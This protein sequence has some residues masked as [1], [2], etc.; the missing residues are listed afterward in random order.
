MGSRCLGGTGPALRVS[1]PFPFA[2]PSLF[3]SAPSSQLQPQFHLGAG[4][5]R[6]GVCFGGEGGH[7]DRASF[8]GVLQSSFC[9][10]QG[11]RWVASGD[12][13]L[14]PQ[15]LGGRLPFPYG[16]CSDRAPVSSG[17]GL[18]GIPGSPGCLPPGSGSSIVSTVPE[19]LRWGLGLPV[20]R[21]LF[22]SLD[23]SPSVHP[24]HGSCVLDHASSRVPH[25]PVPQRLVSPGFDL[26]G[27][28]DIV[29]AR[30]FLLWLYHR[31]DLQDAYLQ[32]PVHPSSRRYL[33]FCVGDSV[34]QFR[35]LCF[36][37]S[38]APQAFTR[39]MAPVSSIMHCHGFR[40]L[41]YLND[42]LVLGST[43]QDIVRARDFLLWLC[44]RLRIM[45]NL[46][47]SSLDPSQTQDYLGMTITT[48]PLRVFLTL[49]QVQKL[50]LLLQEFRSDRLHPVSVWRRL[51]G[52][53]SSMSAIVP[54]AHLRMRSL[55]LRLNASGPLV[56]DEDLVSWDD[57]C[58]RDLR[59][60]SRR[61][62]SLGRPS[63]WRGPPR[64]LPLLRRLGHRLGRGSRRPP[65]LRLVV[66]PVFYLFNQPSRAF[67]SSL[68]GS[69]LSPFAP[70]S[71]CSS[72]F[73]QLHRFSLPQETRGHS[74]VHLECSRSGASLALRGSF[75]S[76]PSPVH[77]RPSE[78]SGGFTQPSFSS[79]GVRVDVVSEGG[80]RSSSPLAYQ[81][82]P[83]RDVP[84]S[85]ASGVL[86]ANVRSAVSWHG[87]HASVVGRPSGL[88]L[89]TFQP[90]SAC[91][92]EGSAFSGWS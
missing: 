59:W 92:G 16:D 70:G 71:S 40:I 69:G 74:F 50:S 53:M 48:S 67:G 7:R 37:V 66:S 13:S 29:R 25:S 17:R 51:L 90:P 54:G 63:T 56:L 31:L 88:C 85:S 4:P 73:G 52:V 32:V 82:R 5:F 87:C 6:P 18:D 76:T 20:S 86:L 21:P 58:L 47:K 57:G 45:V 91:S 10:P 1:G 23:G 15:R 65:S 60:W 64:P 79:P 72:V 34:Y 30:D 62:P 39:I 89:S 44:H 42:W 27:H 41:R 49:K 81:H 68:C 19:V 43:F 75:H 61:I 24:H 26:P 12:R 35:A 14:T 83:L 8:P 22:R 84:Q 80:S 2:A 38:T 11:H 33:R 28:K 55:Q 46:S 3:C 36:S 77:S 9:D 78:C